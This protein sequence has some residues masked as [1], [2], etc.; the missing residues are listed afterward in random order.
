M[1]DNP[2]KTLLGIP[3]EVSAVP[4]REIQFSPEPPETPSVLLID[5][6]PSDIPTEFIKTQLV[7]MFKNRGYEITECKMEKKCGYFMFSDHN[8]R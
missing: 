4:L 8:G 6:L 1:M 5:N 7:F 3:I 2:P